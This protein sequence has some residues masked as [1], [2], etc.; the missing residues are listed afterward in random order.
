[1]KRPTLI[2]A[3]SGASPC[4]DRSVLTVV[5]GVRGLVPVVVRRPVRAGTKHLYH[6]FTPLPDRVDRQ[7]PAT[8][9]EAAHKSDP[10][11][12]RPGSLHRS[13]RTRR[14]HPTNHPRAESRPP[15]PRSRPDPP[16]IR[17]QQPLLHEEAM[18]GRLCPALTHHAIQVH[19]HRMMSSSNTR[20]RPQAVTASD[21]VQKRGVP[22]HDATPVCI[23]GTSNTARPRRVSAQPRPRRVTCHARGTSAGAAAVNPRQVN[24]CTDLRTVDTLNRVFSAISRTLNGPTECRTA[25]T[26]ASLM[27]TPT[28]WIHV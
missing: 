18:R 14:P 3:G 26:R 9:A 16:R 24:A 5:R 7:P 11:A 10:A 1:M 2:A 12:N 23:G 22:T 25:M 17:H 27:C 13:T 21:P 4:F 20:R 15:A 8:D 28:T 19:L 6:S